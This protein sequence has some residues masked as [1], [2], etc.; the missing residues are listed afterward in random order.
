MLDIIA[1][2]L[3]MGQGLIDGAPW[4]AYVLI[5]VAPI[6]M[7]LGFRESMCWFWKVNTLVSRLERIEKR[8]AYMQ[9]DP[10]RSDKLK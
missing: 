7:L 8:L 6:C 4:W 9:D 3:N 5:V 2:V 1:F 10:N